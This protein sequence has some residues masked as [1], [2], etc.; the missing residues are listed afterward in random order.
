M[1]VVRLQACGVMKRRP[2]FVAFL[3]AAIICGFSARAQNLGLWTSLYSTDPRAFAANLRSAGFPEATVGL[4]VSQEINRR[5]VETESRLQPSLATLETLR[6]GWSAG[7]REAL[8]KLRRERN[9][10]LRE[11]LGAVPQETAKS[12]QVPDIIARISPEKREAVSLIVEDYAAMSAQIYT[13][14]RGALL[15]DD[16]AKLRF[17]EKERNIDLGR[18]LGPDEAVD[19]QIYLSGF[20][21]RTQAFLEI[22]KPTAQEVRDIFLVRRKVGLDVEALGVLPSAKLEEMGREGRIELAKLWTPERYAELHLAGSRRYQLVYHIVRRL[23]FPPAVARQLYAAQYSMCE[24]AFNYATDPANRK[25]GIKPTS[26]ELS[27]RLI[28]EHLALVRQLIGEEGL[29][30]YSSGNQRMIDVM[31]RGGATAPEHGSVF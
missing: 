7:R 10:L 8:I 22:A 14:S 6:E 18:I 12:E 30:E 13:E 11:V 28:E 1:T 23:G 29:A 24:T 4:L 16:R 9:D 25:E 31:R 5:F 2:Q 21:R 17:L 20:L 26:A 27:K 19:Y 15:E 3:F